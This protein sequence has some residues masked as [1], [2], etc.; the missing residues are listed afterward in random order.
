MKF[1]LFCDVFKNKFFKLTRVIVVIPKSVEATPKPK[2]SMSNPP[3]AGPRT[4]LKRK[5]I[6]KENYHKLAQTN[7]Y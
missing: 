5:I 4:S 2:F 6:N 3:R 1:K 7:N